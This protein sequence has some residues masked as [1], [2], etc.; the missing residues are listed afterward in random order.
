MASEA[1]GIG[2]S[3]SGGRDGTPGLKV[4]NSLELMSMVFKFLKE[5]SLQETGVKIPKDK[6]PALPKAW[7]APFAPLARVNRAF[8]NGSSNVLWEHMGSVKPFLDLL[9][10]RMDGGDNRSQLYPSL[11][12]T[13]E[14]DRLTLY[15]SKT[16]TLRLHETD[17]AAVD[18]F[19]LFQVLSSRQRPDPLFPALRKLF[20]NSAD[21]NSLFIALSC[22]SPLN[23][24]YF[25]INPLTSD[26]NDA[27]ASMLGQIMNQPLP[28]LTT[29]QLSNPTT[30]SLFHNISKVQS[31]TQL[32][33]TVGD[34]FDSVDLRRLNQLSLLKKL[35]IRQL[36][37]RQSNEGNMPGMV[38]FEAVSSRKSPLVQL[39]ELVVR[40]TGVFHLQVALV[41]S[42]STLKSVELEDIRDAPHID[43]ALLPLALAI[44]VKRNPLLSRVTAFSQISAFLPHSSAA[45]YRAD[46]R[47]SAA[48]SLISGLASLH[49]LRYLHIKSI[50]F[51]A[52]H[53]LVDLHDMVRSHP[54]L[55]E[56]LLRPISVTSLEADQL[57]VPP[58]S[59]LEGLSNV[60]LFRLDTL[61]DCSNVPSPPCHYQSKHTLRRLVL[62]HHP[63][64]LPLET[65][66]N[67]L[68]LAKY[69]DRLFPQLDTIGDV[70]PDGHPAKLFWRYVEKLVKFSQ[71][72]R[73][74]AMLV[75]DMAKSSIDGR[76]HSLRASVL[77]DMETIWGTE[78]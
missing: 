69:I 21:D 51:F 77:S 33:I 32:D 78:S 48:E 38:D 12:S 53:I 15:S 7:T 58:L 20:I 64:H 1:A 66:E 17:T 3:V 27:C 37:L 11:P 19:W 71:D 49:D 54:Q 41:L 4:L 72:A 59:I 16:K 42:P 45:R 70:Y 8:F 68:A 6:P 76:P 61:I 75:Q 44:H 31:L 67:Q 13:A 24:I 29:L 50:P 63:G 2:P 34:D 73:N 36:L 18:K 56:F 26:G 9:Y 5:L 62:I 43:R 65:P 23:A 60:N 14:W 74:H 10:N 52:V 47:F 30:R 35:V 46:P 25:D 40:S 28:Q 39:Q 57:I 55:R 22:A